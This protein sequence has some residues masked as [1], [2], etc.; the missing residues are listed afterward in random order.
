MSLPSSLDDSILRLDIHVSPVTNS[1]KC[2]FSISKAG[3]RWD[4]TRRKSIVTV[5]VHSRRYILANKLTAI[6]NAITAHDVEK[7]TQRSTHK[8]VSRV[9]YL[10]RTTVIK[11]DHA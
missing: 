6:H 4:S 8:T 10:N 3:D 5:E 11:N 1:N 9:R 2:F 7:K